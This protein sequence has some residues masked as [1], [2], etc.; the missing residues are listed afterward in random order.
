MEGLQVLVRDE[1]DN[2]DEGASRGM[3]FLKHDNITVSLCLID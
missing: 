1:D 2:Q 3:I